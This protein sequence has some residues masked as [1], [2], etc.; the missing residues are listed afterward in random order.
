M[1][2]TYDNGDLLNA[3]I[4]TITRA[5]PTLNSSIT[6]AA[7]TISNPVM[8]MPAAKW[9]QITLDSLLEER[10]LN[11]VSVDH[12]VAEHELMKLKES[13]PDYASEIKEKIAREVARD[14]VKKIS[15]TKKKVDDTNHFIGRV[16]VFSDEELKTLLERFVNV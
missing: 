1:N 7:N 12:K 6:A 11:R 13:A 2:D 10:E 4:Q 5:D 9:K 15:F 14:I 3:M 8:T 16:W